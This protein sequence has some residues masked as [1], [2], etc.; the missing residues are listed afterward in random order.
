[1]GEYICG[2]SIRR[3]RETA[4]LTQKDLAQAVGVTDKAVSKW[5]TGRGLPDISLL[6]PLAKVL[7]VS[8]AELLAGD[9][10]VNAN[11][12]GNMMRSRFYVCPICG[13]VLFASGDASISCCGVSLPVLEPE[14]AAD[15]HAISCEVAD[16][17]VYVTIDH[18]MSKEHFISF[19]AYVTSDR[20]QLRKLYPEQLAEAR[21]TLRGSGG[22]YCFCNRHELF[23]QRVRPPKRNA[24]T[25]R[26]V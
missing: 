7:G 13:N 20:V 23:S 25:N 15:D 16:G 18:P 4:Q 21:F 2:E 14:E 6:D 1:M 8:L 17:E 22:V 12:A 11:K 3:L 26:L 19:I 10:E 5:E 9:R 24:P